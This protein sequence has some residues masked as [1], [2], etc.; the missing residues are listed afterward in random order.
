MKSYEVACPEN[1]IPLTLLM[2]YVYSIIVIH[3]EID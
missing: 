3:I 1:E 2:I